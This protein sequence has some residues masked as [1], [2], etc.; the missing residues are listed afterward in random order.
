[1]DCSPPGSSVYEIFQTRILEWV[2]ISFS[3]VSSQA[4][5]GTRVS[6][7]AGRFFADWATIYATY[8]R[9]GLTWSWLS[10]NVRCYTAATD[11]REE[12]QVEDPILGRYSWHF[13]S[14]QVLSAT[15]SFFPRLSTEPMLTCQH[16]K[17]QTFSKTLMKSWNWAEYRVGVRLPRGSRSTDPPSPVL[18]QIWKQAPSPKLNLTGSQVEDCFGPFCHNFDIHTHAPTQLARRSESSPYIP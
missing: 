8:L 15:Y 17:V 1:M 18:E 10:R 7:T 11:D 2:A 6:C 5:D 9:W 12:E 16:V 3:R 14:C 4:R 13:S